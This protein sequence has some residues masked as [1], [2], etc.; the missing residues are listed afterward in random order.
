VFVLTDGSGG[1][2]TSRID[3]SR[4]LLGA[5]GASPAPQFG[6]L[7]DREAYAL[8]MHRDVQHLQRLVGDLADALNRLAPRVVAGDALEGFNPVHDLCRVL[9]DSACELLDITDP[10]RNLAFSLTG[11]PVP[12]PESVTVRLDDAALARKIAAARAYTA[13]ED[14]VQRMIDAAGGI[15][16]FGVEV[17]QPQ[18]GRQWRPAAFP[19]HYETVGRRRVQEGV[20][21]DALT[22]DHFRAAADVIGDY[23][24]MHR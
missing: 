23:V 24:A 10:R 17:L 1:R 15:D 5:I 3:D 12:T 16:A 22:Y 14:D 20:Y 2:A 18:R 8:L 6:D 7:T 19:P 13:I 11:A 21:R 4:E 9:I